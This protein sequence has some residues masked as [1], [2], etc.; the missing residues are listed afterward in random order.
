MKSKIKPNRNIMI[1]TTKTAPKAPPGNSVNI[2]VIK[3][4]PPKPLNTREKIEEPRSI[5]NTM[6]VISAVVSTASV[7]F[8]RFKLLL[9]IARR[10]APN[11]P[12]PAASVG[13]AI[14]R[15]IEPSTDEINANGGSREESKIFHLPETI[16][17]SW[18]GAIFG[19]RYALIIT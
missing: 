3:S 12:T 19:E 15:S 16:V 9:L 6:A 7:K 11:A 14:P 8:F 13:V 4:S 5:M 18:A 17:V 1:I 2:P 10:I